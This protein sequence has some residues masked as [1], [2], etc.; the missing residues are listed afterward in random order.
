MAVSVAALLAASGGLA[1]A[2]ISGGPVIHACANKKTG[3]LR[4]ASKCRR[5]ERSISWNQRGQPGQ[6]GPRG[7]AGPSGSPGTVNGVAAGGDLAGTYPNPSI[8]PGTVTPPKLG[9]VP[10]VAVTNSTNEPVGATLTF[11]TARFDPFGMHSATTNP[12]RLTAPIAGVYLVDANVCFSHS[13]TG[14]RDLEI[15]QNGKTVSLLQQP[16]NGAA[17]TT[18]VHDSAQ[19]KLNA[20]EYVELFPFV[21]EGSVEVERALGTPTFAATWIAH[22]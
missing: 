2:A 8:A 7:V 5:G 6:P 17:R 9:A 20:G 11:D 14:D 1:V 21:S 3:V 13:A 10:T 18:C 15:E 16:N 19:L 22:G 12:S 4:L